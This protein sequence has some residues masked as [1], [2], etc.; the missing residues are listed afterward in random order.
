MSQN[1]ESSNAAGSKRRTGSEQDQNGLV[2]LRLEH[3]GL[4]GA[5]VLR[6]T[7]PNDDLRLARAIE[8]ICAELVRRALNQTGD[9]P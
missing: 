6:L 3:R 1:V 9:N 8:G 7:G 4:R 5:V 2:R